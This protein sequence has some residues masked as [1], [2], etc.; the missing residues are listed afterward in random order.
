MAS[1]EY[2]MTACDPQS[3]FLG[4]GPLRDVAHV[5]LDDL[6]VPLPI[7]VADKLHGNRA[8]IARFQ[9]QVF[10]AD[11]PLSLQLLELGLVGYDVP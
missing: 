9:R 5:T 11:T 2:S 1:S 7:N 10:V 4:F 6:G 8:A 3:R